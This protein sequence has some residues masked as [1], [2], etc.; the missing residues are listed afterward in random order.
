[1]TDASFLAAYKSTALEEVLGE[2]IMNL[3][4][5][6]LSLA[7]LRGT[8][9]MENVPLDGD[10]LIRHMFSGMGLL[11]QAAGGVG[12]QTGGSTADPFGSASSNNTASASTLPNNTTSSGQPPPIVLNSSNVGVLS[13]VAEKIVMTIPWRKL[14]VEPTSCWVSGVHLLCVPLTP[15]TATRVYQTTNTT[16]DSSVPLRTLSKQCALARLERVYWTGLMHGPG[17]PNDGGNSREGPTMKKIV[18][19][20]KEVK[21]DLRRK[22]K[23]QQ[24]SS[25]RTPRR[26]NNKDDFE[27]DDVMSEDDDEAAMDTIVNSLS[28]RNSTAASSDTPTTNNTT[29]DADAASVASSVTSIPELPRDWKV[30]LREKV[31]RNLEATL[32]N[33]HVRVEVAGAADDESSY[34]LGATLE[35]LVGRTADDQWTVGRHDKATLA[36]S[37]ASRPHLGPN[38]YVIKNNKIAYMTNFSMYWDEDPPF[39]LSEADALQDPRQFH[40]SIKIMSPERLVSRLAAAMDAMVAIQEPGI[41]IRKSLSYSLTASAATGGTQEPE[42]IDRPHQYICQNVCAE[43]RSRCSDRTQPGP[44]SCTADVQPCHWTISIRPT[45]V[46]QYHSLRS[47]MQ[48]QQRYDTMIRPRPSVSPKQDPKA[49][50]RYVI[51]CVISRPNWRPWPDVQRITKHRARYVDLVLQTQVNTTAF[52]RSNINQLSQTERYE[53]WQ[54][55]DLLPIEAL[56]AYHLLALRRSYAQKMGS[57]FWGTGKNN[58]STKSPVR[59]KARFSFLGVGNRRNRDS[60]STSTP[61]STPPLPTKSPRKTSANTLLRPIHSPLGEELPLHK[62]LWAE[63]S[64]S[65]QGINSSFS[66]ATAA[67]PPTA[68]SLIDAMTLRLGRKTW[69]VDCRVIDTTVTVVMQ[70]GSIRDD[71]VA[72]L[73]VSGNLR[74]FG[75]GQRDLILDVTRCDLH[76]GNQKVLFLSPSSSDPIDEDLD[77][78]MMDPLDGI[79][80]TLDVHSSPWSLGGRSSKRKSGPDLKT[81]SHFLDPP[82]EGTVCRIVAGKKSDMFKLSMSAHPLTLVWTTAVFEGLS[83]FLRTSDQAVSVDQWRHAATPLARKAQFAL[84]N[85]ASSAVFLNIAAPKVWVPIQDR[86]LF[87]DA[88]TIQLSTSK[89]EGQIDTDWNIDAR[90]LQ[91]NFVQQ[92]SMASMRFYQGTSA[93]LYTMSE[94]TIFTSGRG[95]ESSVIKPFSIQATSKVTDQGVSLRDTSKGV[96]FEGQVRTLVVNISPLGL[97]LV[98]AEVLA[99]SFGRWYGRIIRKLTAKTEKGGTNEPSP[100]EKR[101]E[102]IVRAD[103]PQTISLQLQKIEVAMEGHSKRRTQISFDDR[104]LESYDS[105]LELSPPIRTYLLEILEIS[106]RR[107][108]IDSVE[109]TQFSVEDASIVRLRDGSLYSPFRSKREAVDSSNCILVRSKPDGPVSPA[110]QAT[111]AQSSPG[112]SVTSAESIMKVSFV[113]DRTSHSNEVEVDIQSILVRVTPTT[114]KDCTKAVRRIAELVQ[115]TTRE[116]ERKVHEAGRKA[117][118]QGRDGMLHRSESLFQSASDRPLSPSLSD[119][120]ITEFTAGG[121]DRRSISGAPSAVDS[122]ILFKIVLKESTLLAG[123]PTSSTEKIGG[124]PRRTQNRRVEYAVIQ[125]LSNALIMFQSIENPDGTGHKTLHISLDNVSSLVN[126]EFERVAPSV[127]PPMI[128]PFG[129][130][131]RVVYATENLGCVVSQDASLNCEE[132]KSHLTPNDLS[133][134]ISVSRRMVD[135]LRA[136]GVSHGGESADTASP[137]AKPFHQ[138]ASLIRYQKKGTGIATSVRTEIH[139]FSFVLLRAFKSHFGAPEFLDFNVE[140]IKLKLDG[141]MSALSGECTSMLSVNSFN[142]EVE[143]WE[144]AVEPFPLAIKVEQMPNELVRSNSIDLYA[145]SVLA[146]TIWF[147]FVSSSSKPPRKKISRLISLELCYAI[148]QK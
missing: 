125:V 33:V 69:Y 73:R 100:E 22:K 66:N 9:T 101:I 113:R 90:D 50:W 104:S 16:S 41:A 1:M 136:F 75:Q 37:P 71:L 23:Q 25:P 77:R 124:S 42:Q 132:V 19:A 48:T 130:E 102:A 47:A 72:V 17:G 120:Q 14:E 67:A 105:L 40:S 140:Q 55:Q 4:R 95:G 107:S 29:T 122:S 144:Y 12:E 117:R 43:I 30:K 109:T 70:P 28:E 31:L 36:V 88:G 84:L 96:S 94:S 76:H 98:D 141:C 56:L 89:S 2:Y 59:P 13:C 32:E 78:G 44:I 38:P 24:R 68:M 81:P 52:G 10:V 129:M 8:L 111:G 61:P 45:Q 26:G 51:A 97:N 106:V 135:R 114:L 65:R 134:L 85:P 145:Q 128:G 53:L 99:R 82:P 86:A 39:L 127:A 58:S 112:C 83:N 108:I 34:C 15:T 116:M 123:R 115:V 139:A 21:R 126:T 20:V 63:N 64:T 147:L 57:S 46:K 131:F 6:Q 11:Q 62:P 87:I 27:G 121:F 103:L 91:V 93:E 133:I 18:R 92:S 148:L 49:W 110:G 80:S 146:L 5:E 138:L 143:D 137:K 118:R 142:S 79:L 60:T 54:L 35:K 3:P 119:D 7:A 74:S